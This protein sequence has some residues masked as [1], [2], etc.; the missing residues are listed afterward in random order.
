MAAGGWAVEWLRVGKRLRAGGVLYIKLQKPYSRPGPSPGPT[1]ICRF[2]YS[3]SRPQ[4][5]PAAHK[6]PQA[7][8]LVRDHALWSHHDPMRLLNTPENPQSL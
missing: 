8:T 7:P 4:A 5:P 1:E 2:M 6:R 3:P